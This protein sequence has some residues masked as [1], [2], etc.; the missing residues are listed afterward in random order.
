ML[1]V[2][3]E[4]EQLEADETVKPVAGLAAKEKS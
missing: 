1:N 2:V 4:V 3:A